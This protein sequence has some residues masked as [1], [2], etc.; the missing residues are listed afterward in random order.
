MLDI[1]SSGLLAQ[2]ASYVIELKCDFI[3]CNDEADGK[4]FSENVLY[5]YEA[6]CT[7][8]PEQPI[9]SDISDDEEPGQVSL[10]SEFQNMYTDV[11]SGNDDSTGVTPAYTVEAAFGLSLYILLWLQLQ[12]N[13]T[14]LLHSC[15]KRKCAPTQ[16][17]CQVGCPC[18]IA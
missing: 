17:V 8:E 10:Q 1:V 9:E 14:R 6:E 2:L 3:V 7:C 15:T 18:E 4:I 11:G 13:V 12:M 16:K 5:T